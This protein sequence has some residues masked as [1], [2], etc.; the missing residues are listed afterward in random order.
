[1]N[2]PIALISPTEGL[3]LKKMTVLLATAHPPLPF[4]WYLSAG[5]APQEAL[6]LV[7]AP[8]PGAIVIDPEEGHALNRIRKAH[9]SE[10]PPSQLPHHSTSPGANLGNT[11]SLSTLELSVIPVLSSGGVGASTVA[12]ALSQLLATTEATILIDM[13]MKAHLGLYH[14]LRAGEHALDNFRL[15]MQTGPYQGVP[16]PVPVPTRGYDLLGTTG[17][18]A[19]WS[20][21]TPAHLNELISSLKQE[22]H[23]CVIDLEPR[24]LTT[25]IAGNFDWEDLGSVPRAL[26]RGATTA[27]MVAGDTLKGIFDGVN[28]ARE[29]LACTKGLEALAVVVV[30]SRNRHGLQKGASSS[31]VDLLHKVLPAHDA[32]QLKAIELPWVDL[33]DTHRTV[34]GFP[35]SLLKA[36]RPLAAL[37]TNAQ[38][39]PRESEP[40]PLNGQLNVLAESLNLISKQAALGDYLAR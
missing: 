9:Q 18:I 3:W 28:L 24:F 16:T 6:K 38:Y 40:R 13:T 20:T 26:L 25:E 12:M 36:L 15:S 22:Y 2:D 35:H 8:T 11:D 31:L 5:E 37:A 27:A 39:R 17:A 14:D 23:C 7:A 1:M 19:R 33:E 29:I 34:K 32:P 10:P 21:L 30:P 4:R